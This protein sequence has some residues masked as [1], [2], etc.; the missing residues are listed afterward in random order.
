MKKRSLHPL[1]LLVLMLASIGGTLAASPALAQQAPAKWKPRLESII[2]S[3][4]P[5][6]NWHAILSASRLGSAFVVSASIPVPYSDL[7]LAQEP[8]ASELGR[9][10]QVAAHLVCLELDIKYP[11]SQYPIVEGYEGYDCARIAANDGMTRA[12]LLIANAKQ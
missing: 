1:M 10:I 9:R 6:R 4:A 2:V 3:A 11:P 12:N 8:G 7:D 5:T